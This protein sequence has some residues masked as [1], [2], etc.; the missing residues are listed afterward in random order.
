VTILIRSN[1]VD[2]TANRIKCSRRVLYA[3]NTATN[4]E[5]KSPAAIRRLSSSEMGKLTKEQLKHA[6]KTMIDDDQDAKL[7]TII[8]ELSEM[9]A[10]R[11][12]L[13]KTVDMLSNKVDI[14]EQTAAKQQQ[15]L[16]ILEKKR[17]EKNLIILGIEEKEI[18]NQSEKITLREQRKEV[19]NALG[20]AELADNS[21]I[22]CKR[23]GKRNP[24]GSTRSRPILV[25]LSNINTKYE[26]LHKAP[27]LKTADE[28]FKRVFV[29]PDL[30]PNVRKEIDRLKKVAKAEKEKAENVHKHVIY[31]HK[32]RKVMVGDTAVDSFQPVQYF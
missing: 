22:E 17:R 1:T 13:L 18:E 29:K 31:D 11:Q 19:F 23:L 5:G 4:M 8:N 2:L 32:Q 28:K 27:R 10:E 21:I 14:L 6:L 24:E 3:V 25:E 9:K 15:Y 30:H 12:I 16:E 26:I 7:T 20:E